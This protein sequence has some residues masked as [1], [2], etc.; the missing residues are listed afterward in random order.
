[1]NPIVLSIPLVDFHSLGEDAD[2]IMAYINRLLYMKG[3]REC[4]EAADLE[5]KVDAEE[6]NLEFR[7]K[8]QHREPDFA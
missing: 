8:G 1:M 3:Y 7:F 4:V 6:T 5:F 2:I